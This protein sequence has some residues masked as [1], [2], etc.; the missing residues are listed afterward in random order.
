MKETPETRLEAMGLKLPA[1]PQPLANYVPVLLS[2]DLLFVSGQ[3]SRHADGS[4]FTGRLGADV[5]LNDGQEAARSSALSILAHAKAAL[6]TLDKIVQVVRLTG[7]VAS[8]PHFKEQPQVVNGAS[9]LFVAVLGDKGR[10]ARSA[11]GVACLPAGAA[12]EVDA[13]L[14]VKP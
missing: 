4:V 10:H 2:G 5:S 3:I 8:A 1:A 9:D 13:I 12:V 11:V 7:F 6:G 14:K